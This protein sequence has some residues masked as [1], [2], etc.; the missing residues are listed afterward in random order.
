MSAIKTVKCDH[1]GKT[2][3][4]DERFVYMPIVEKPVT[5]S[6]HC[7]TILVDFCSLECCQSVFNDAMIKIF[8]EH[9]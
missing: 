5:Y 9:K 6:S 1:C 2:L 3:H 7:G 8:G 4:E